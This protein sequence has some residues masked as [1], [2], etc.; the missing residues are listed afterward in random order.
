MDIRSRIRVAPLLLALAAATAVT[1]H[2]VAQGG[3]PPDIT[4]NWRLDNAEDPGQPPLADYLGI[5]FNAAGRLRADTTPESIW[6]TPEY[7]CRPHSL[8]HQWRGVGG[9]RILAE[10][11]P[12]TR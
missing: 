12:L 1:V 7:Q 10:Q 11:D 4:G 6:D 3:R 2:P 9:A 5:P 8:P